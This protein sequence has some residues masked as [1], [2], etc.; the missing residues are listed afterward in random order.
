MYVVE[1]V[2]IEV[3]GAQGEHCCVP[4]PR[5]TWQVLRCTLD[6]PVDTKQ[7]CPLRM[8][9]P[10]IVVAFKLLTLHLL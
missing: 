5:P 9:V 3:T 8:R 10:L 1:F 7:A 6:V 2:Y 4:G